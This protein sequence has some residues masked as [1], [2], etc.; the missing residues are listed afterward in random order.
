[1]KRVLFLDIDGVLNS[2]Y[3]FKE[4]PDEDNRPYPLSEFDPVLIRRLNQILIDGKVTDLVVSS[5]WRFTEGLDNIF[6]EVG[7]LDP[8]HHKNEKLDYIGY[9][10][11]EDHRRGYEIRH[12]LSRNTVD[13]YCIL[14]DMEFFLNDQQSNLVLTDW[15]VGLTDK[16]V[17]TAIKIL[18][19]EV[20]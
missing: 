5:D 20:Y 19:N 15:R 6:Q 9:V 16:D 14:D 17:I 18:N 13:S 7:I 11:D 3:Y 2:D 8:F 1:M 4:R 10:P 12:Y